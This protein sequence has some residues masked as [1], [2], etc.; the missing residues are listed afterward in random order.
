MAE[1]PTGSRDER[2]KQCLLGM[3]L[4]GAGEVPFTPQSPI[5]VPDGVECQ[6]MPR[7]AARD[8][9]SATSGRALALS[10]IDAPG[11]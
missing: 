3:T 7:S 5:R 8:S 1:E 11:A 6:A 4:A 2:I 10:R 9:I